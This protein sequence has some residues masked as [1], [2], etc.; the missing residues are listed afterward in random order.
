MKEYVEDIRKTVK[1][2]QNTSTGVVI[3]KKIVRKRDFVQPTLRPGKT[4]KDQKNGAHA[5]AAEN[6]QKRD[7][8][9]QDT[10]RTAK[11]FPLHS[12]NGKAS[13]ALRSKK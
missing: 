12:C 6:R 8:W 10:R 11:T 4:R 7:A 3:F 2:K 9:L 1:V 13:K 5:T